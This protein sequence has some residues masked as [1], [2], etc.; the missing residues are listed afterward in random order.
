[1]LELPAVYQRVISEVMLSA[2]WLHLYWSLLLPEEASFVGKEWNILE[3]TCVSGLG[4]CEV[5]SEDVFGPRRTCSAPK[6]R[7]P[8]LHQTQNPT[9]IQSHWLE[10]QLKPVFF[11]NKTKTK[12]KTNFDLRIYHVFGEWKRQLPATVMAI[13]TDHAAPL[14]V[15]GHSDSL[16]FILLSVSML[17]SNRKPDG[18]YLF[19]II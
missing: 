3:S 14:G 17:T 16:M 8:S 5:D 13:S 4:N 7:M 15:S 11:T 2:S 19:S 6:I 10:K 1:M 18:E 9:G 12:N